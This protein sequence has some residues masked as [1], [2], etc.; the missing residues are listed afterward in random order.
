MPIIKYVLVADVNTDARMLFAV[1]ALLV[2]NRP[3][4]VYANQTLSVAQTICVCHVSI[5]RKCAVFFL[6]N[7]SRCV[8]SI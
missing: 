8:F 3:A 7:H 6:E 2:I 1:L 5:C 4:D